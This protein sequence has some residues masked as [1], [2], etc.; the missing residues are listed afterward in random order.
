MTT[1]QTPALILINCMALMCMPYN[2]PINIGFPS[3]EKIKIHCYSFNCSFHKL[4]KVLFENLH[5]QNGYWKQKSY[6]T[7][8]S[9]FYWLEIIEINVIST[10]I[11]QFC[12]IIKGENVISY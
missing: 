1:L 4:R 12:I 7:S 9:S 5:T 11:R 6:Q 10:E 3:I 2:N 8:S